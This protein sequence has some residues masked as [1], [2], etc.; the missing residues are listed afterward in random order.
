[1][2][3][4][5]YVLVEFVD[6]VLPW[7]QVFACFQPGACICQPLHSQRFGAQECLHRGDKGERER[8]RDVVLRKKEEAIAQPSTLVS[9]VGLP[10]PVR[11]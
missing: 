3:S 7:T 2:W 5:L 6:G 1:M 10:Q 9:N 11:P 8:D 4:L